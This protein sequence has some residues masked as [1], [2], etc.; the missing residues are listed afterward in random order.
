MSETATSSPRA[1]HVPPLCSARSI[2]ITLPLPHKALSPNGRPHWRTLAGA[3]KKAKLAGYLATIAAGG[4]DLQW[5]AASIEPTFI[6][7]SKR[8]ADADHDNRIAS[9]KAFC[10]G[11]A[12][13]GL[14]VNDRVFRWREV[15]HDVDKNDPRLV[16]VVTNTGA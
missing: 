4:Q 7:K 15:R 14:V 9:C 2:T 12:A 8:Y 1:Q 13:A 6:V 10:D 16:L 5:A 11:I 3:K